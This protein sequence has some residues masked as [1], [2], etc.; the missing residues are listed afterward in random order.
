M[1]NYAIVRRVLEEI[2]AGSDPRAKDACDLLRRIRKVD[3]VAKLLILLD[4]YKHL[5][6]VS[7]DLQQVDHPIWLKAASLRAYIT[8]LGEMQTWNHAEPQYH[9]EFFSHEA[10]LEAC[11]FADLPLLVADVGLMLP[12]R[13]TRQQADND[14]TDPDTGDTPVNQAS[15]NVLTRIK[16]NG[17]IM[18]ETMH[19][20]M[21]ERFPPTYF[22][23]IN[24]QKKSASLLLVLK[25]A[26]EA[27]SESDLLESE[28]VKTLSQMHPTQTEGIRNLSLNISRNTASLVDCNTDVQLY[29]NVYSDR[30]LFIGAEHVLSEIAKIICSSPPESIVESMGSIIEKIRQA[31]GG[32]KSS[33]NRKDVDDISD[34]LLIHWN[35]PPISN[36]DSIVRQALNI[37]FKG[38]SWHFTATDVR[39]R[40]H[41]VSAV[42]DRLNKTKSK[43]N[44]MN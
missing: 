21:N 28:E 11:I 16:H 43:L 35:G 22:T 27:E 7:R 40:R 23:E 41:K 26:R 3:F 4:F 13:R 29:H 17:S 12:L 15:K 32:S 44:F 10:E 2:A 6:A 34:E 8:A 9:E 14:A 1:D 5:G 18:A 37:H 36:C 39:A 33:T 20:H 25:R 30:N 31:R 42:V 38:A 19:R 24:N